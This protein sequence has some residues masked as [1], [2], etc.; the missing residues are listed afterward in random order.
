M[1]VRVYPGAKSPTHEISL[2]DGVNTW[3][4]RLDGGPRA[5]QEVPMTPSTLQFTGGGSKF[6]DWE[7]G[8]SHIEQRT[9]IGGRGSD[10]FASDPTRFFDSH[11][12]FTMVDGKVFPASQWKLGACND[13][14]ET[15]EYMP[16]NVNWQAL[17]GEKRF[18][19]ID[20][21]VGASAFDAHKIYIWLRR[22]GSPNAVTY[23]IYTDNSGNPNDLHSSATGTVDINDVTDVVSRWIAV[24]VSA[25]SNLADNTKYHVVIFANT[26]DNAANH[27]EVGVDKV[28]SNSK[29]SSDGASWS[30]AEFTLYHRVV[31]ASTNRRIYYFLFRGALYAVDRKADGS[32]SELFINGDRGKCTTGGEATLQDTNKSWTADEWIGAWVQIIAGTGKGQYREITDNTTD[33]L[34]VGTWDINPDSTSVYVIYATNIW[35]NITPTSG[36]Q[37]DTAVTGPPWV[38]EKVAYFPRGNG[39][40]IFKMQYNEGASPPVHEFRDDTGDKADLI[41]GFSDDTN[42]Y[43]L[44]VADNSVMTLIRFATVAYASNLASGTAIDV[45]DDSAGIVNI[46]EHNDK[47]WVFKE[48]GFYEI[49]SDKAIKKASGMDFVRSENTGEALANR[50]FYLYS[51]WGGFE[52]MQMQE[53]AAMIDMASIGPNRGEGLPNDRRGPVTAILPHPAGLFA[54]I[55]GGNEGYSSVLV[56]TDPVGW[57]EVFRS[58]EIGLRIRGLFWQ[59]CPGTRP[60]LWIDGG[61]DMFYQEWP[62]NAINPL[63]DNGFVFQH[64]CSVIS[65]TI[66][67]GAALLPKF[68]KELNLI[69]ENLTTGIEVHLEYQVDNDI[70]TSTWIKAET[71]YSSPE[72]SLEIN[73]GNVKRIRYRLRLLTNDADVPPVIFSTVLEGF[74]RTPLK[75]QWNMRIKISDTQRDLSGGNVDYDPD[76]FLTWLKDAA[77]GAR[78][79]YMRSIWEQMDGRYVIVEPPSTLRQFTNNILGFWGGAVTVTVREG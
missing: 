16:G 74:A 12:A 78:R 32:A 4:L 73:K 59:D 62:Q 19:S 58:P 56:R 17:L 35:Q 38:A 33:T 46:T 44:Y 69:S 52:L 64:E 50:N 9:W 47:L 60:R 45:G 48:D 57:H 3:G 15:Y 39:S 63:K 1:V 36:D 41:Y 65:S 40:N 67:M 30:D 68:I 72:D 28:E 6:G 79:I 22:I 61:D 18:V 31:A 37:F 14:K 29:C 25:A 77:I 51:S 7:P 13:F 75:Y 71:F 20:F 8:M 23:A 53:N 21:T 10:D 24:N 76:E 2:S 34:T 26:N 55:D 70:E 49:D 43:R 11:M 54:A 42:G 66:D 27:W 5:L